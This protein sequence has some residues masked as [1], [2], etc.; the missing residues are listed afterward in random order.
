VEYG[1]RVAAEVKNGPAAVQQVRLQ[2]DQSNAVL[3]LAREHVQGLALVGPGNGVFVP[4]DEATHLG[5]YFKKGDTVGYV[6]DPERGTTV[7]LAVTEYEAD[8]IRA[9]GRGLLARFVDQPERTY[10][11]RIVRE[12][13][14][15]RDTLPSKALSTEGA[16]PFPLDP[17][18]TQRLKS[19]DHVIVFECEV[20]DA[21][22]LDRVG[23]RV[24]VRLDYGYAP[25]AE[26]L[27]RPL[28]QLL[29]RQ[30]KL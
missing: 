3:A 9:R 15:A 2:L 21:P 25:M 10:H 1:A 17:S 29:L 11:A 4:Y 24:I 13:P 27:Y 5:R 12:V 26:Q 14:A 16:G 20:L 28:R 19:L 30:L 6:I 8:L 7:R 23:G 18:D 22:P